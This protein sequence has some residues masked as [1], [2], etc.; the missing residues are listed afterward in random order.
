MSEFVHARYFLAVA[1]AADRLPR[2]GGD[3]AE[4]VARIE[5]EHDELRLAL[6]W[7]L[8]AEPA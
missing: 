3:Q 2:A 8:G 6:A 5:S 4:A 1:E 7:S